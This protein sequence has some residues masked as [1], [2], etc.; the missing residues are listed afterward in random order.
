MNSLIMSIKFCFCKDISAIVIMEG[1]FY[2]TSI[3][4]I[5]KPLYNTRLLDQRAGVVID[6]SGLPVEPAESSWCDEVGSE[7]S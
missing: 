4:S 1:L 3:I 6:L 5:P 7:V 2:Y